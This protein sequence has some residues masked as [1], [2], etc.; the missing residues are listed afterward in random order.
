MDQLKTLTLFFMVVADDDKIIGQSGH[1]LAVEWT[2]ARLQVI[3]MA[4]NQQQPQQGPAPVSMT[5]GLVSMGQQVDLC[6]LR[7]SFR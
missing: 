6:Q 3:A 2:C 5:S 7:T 4:N 1:F